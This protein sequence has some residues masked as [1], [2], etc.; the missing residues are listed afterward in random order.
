MIN[1]I[2]LAVDTSPYARVASTYANFF[3]YKLDAVLEAV[4]V[5]DSRLTNLTYW[6]DYGALSVPLT[7][8][9][10][11]MAEVL[12]GQG[13]LLLERV[14]EGTEKVGIRCRVEIHEGLPAPTILEAAKDCDLIILGRRGESAM[15]ENGKGL[16]AAAERVLRSA[17]HPVLCT[18]ASFQE[19]GRV[20]LGFDG[21]DRAQS[22]MRYAVE[23]ARRLALEFLAVSISADEAVSAKRNEIVTNYAEAHGIT[24]LTRS[25]RGDPV[26]GLLAQ[27]Q[28]GDMLAMGAFGEGRVRQLLLGSTTE[29]IL[30]EVDHPVLL[31]R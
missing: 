1:S 13:E 19:V 25:L 4:Y 31:H 30:R 8:F 14:R 23:L 6:T 29:A 18:P 27:L 28:P 10:E 17:H 22:A 2:L 12:R 20:V 15:L 3:A 21:S 11:E 26:E 16:G 7:R 5:V 24:A 9:S